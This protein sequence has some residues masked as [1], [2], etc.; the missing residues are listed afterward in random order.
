MSKPSGNQTVTQTPDEQTQ[1]Y[2]DYVWDR[3][4]DVANQP[5]Q[6]YQGGQIAGANP[7][8]QQSILQTGQLPGQLQNYQQQGAVLQ[9]MNR[10]TA[11]Q[12]GV[13]MNAL[14]GDQNAINTLMNPYQKGVI[15][16]VKGQY[17]DLNAAAQTGI[18]DAATK[19]GAY[20]GS[21]HGVA[22][23]IASGEIAKGLGQQ[24]AGL[25]QSGYNDMMGRAAGLAGL[26]QNAMGMAQ[27]NLGY[28]SGLTGAQAG[29]QGQLFGQ[30]DYLR[31]I[32]QQQYDRNVQ[33]FNTQRDWGLRGL[34]ALQGASG[35]PYGQTTSQP[36]YSNPG[37]GFLGGAA[38][39]AGVGGMIGGPIGGAIGAGIGGLAGLF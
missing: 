29:L 39:G 19:A 11:Q 25:Q 33:D 20:G 37:A 26:G 3:A 5:Y 10:N 32:K 7:G 13:G 2:R 28:Q 14:A 23:G 38:T 22:S 35:M 1:R 27:Q 34:G 31:Q 12:A 21:R 18:Q 9:T 6:G 16:Q 30:N 4:K 15:D 17:G 36:M 24:I 8:M